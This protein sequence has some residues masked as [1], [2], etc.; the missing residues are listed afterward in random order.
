MTYAFGVIY[1]RDE[2][3]PKRTTLSR[4]GWTARSGA[5]WPRVEETSDLSFRSSSDDTGS[6]SSLSTVTA[7]A[8]IFSPI[9][10]GV[11]PSGKEYPSRCPSP[12]RGLRRR[13]FL[14][15]ISFPSKQYSGLLLA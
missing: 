4:L 5:D 7:M 3:A 13:L 8:S 10:R 11:G 9:S 12:S 2:Q 1:E 6:T 14:L 15:P